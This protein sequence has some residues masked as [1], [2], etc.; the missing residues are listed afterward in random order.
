MHDIYLWRIRGMAVSWLSAAGYYV[1][2][3]GNDLMFWFSYISVF[4]PVAAEDRAGMLLGTGQAR[5]DKDA[6]R[7]AG[8]DRGG[9][10]GR[11]AGA[12]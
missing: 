6:G 3:S 12:V 2:Q 11:A 8:A 4:Q 7:G 1:N 5:A 10:K 9:R